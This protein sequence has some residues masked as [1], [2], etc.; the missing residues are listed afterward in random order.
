MSVIKKIGK[1]ITNPIKKTGR[2][3]DKTIVQPVI[4][5]VKKPLQKQIARAQKN[6]LNMTPSYDTQRGAS[7]NITYRHSK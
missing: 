2:A 5:P 4:K 7:A 6:G 1:N 3:F